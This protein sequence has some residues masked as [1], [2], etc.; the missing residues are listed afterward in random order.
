MNWDSSCGNISAGQYLSRT[1]EKTQKS[2]LEVDPNFEI[3]TWND[4]FD[5]YHNATSSYYMVNGDLTGSWNGLDSRTIVMNWNPANSQKQISSLK[6]FS[7]RGHKQ[8]IALYYDDTTLAK[9]DAWLK[10]LDEAEKQG[11]TG[12]D[13]FMYTTWGNTNYGDLERVAEYIKTK[14]PSRWPK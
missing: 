1:I 4:M 8:V 14:Y 10:S 9:T 7:N 6:F 13:G 3:Y 12:V 2:I 5:P 11:V